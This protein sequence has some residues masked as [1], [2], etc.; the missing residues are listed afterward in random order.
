MV[1]R[2]LAGSFIAAALVTTAVA[3]GVAAGDHA[4]ERLQ[5]IKHIVVIYEENHSFDN[6]YGSWEGVNGLL[7]APP[8]K[9]VQIKQDGTAFKCLKQNDANLTTPPLS[10]TCVDT[11]GT[12]VTPAPPAFNSHFV[13]APF[14]LDDYIHPS[15]LT[16]P[17]GDPNGQPGG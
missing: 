14:A 5:R 16:C 11:P 15:S 3:T 4:S 6:L 2:L 9:L 7:Q 1:R 13:S 12:A 10:V 8:E 17:N